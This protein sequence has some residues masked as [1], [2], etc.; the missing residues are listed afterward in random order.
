ME[1]LHIL[2]I[3]TKVIERYRPR[4]NIFQPSTKK[5]GLA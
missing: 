1:Y 5:L 4:I 2:F 3:E